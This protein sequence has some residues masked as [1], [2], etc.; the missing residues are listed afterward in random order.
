MGRGGLTAITY[1]KR[2]HSESLNIIIFND[3]KGLLA[4]HKCLG[5]W[6][7]FVQIYNYYYVPLTSAFTRG[8][9]AMQL[10]IICFSNYNMNRFRSG[11]ID[12]SQKLTLFE[13]HDLN[14]FND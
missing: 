11:D 8:V 2:E 10:L 5:L 14:L 9:Y 12:E 4:F 1:L 13:Q 7:G 3:V 6:L